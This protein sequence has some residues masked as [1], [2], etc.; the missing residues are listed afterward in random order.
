MSAAPDCLYAA[1]DT[2]PAPKGAA[3]HIR[4]FA[5]TLFNFFGNGL[6]LTLGAPELPSW[7]HEAGCEI[8][9]LASDENNYLKRAAEF[10]A[11]VGFHAGLLRN[12]LKIAHFRDPWGGLPILN[13]IAEQC[14]TVYE[15]NALP[16]IELP[17]RFR[18]IPAATLS[19]IIASEMECL[20]RADAVICPSEVIRNC[21]VGLGIPAEK[22][23]LIR[24]GATILDPKAFPRPDA[25]PE[26][27]L[28]YFGA[29][30]T[31]QGIECLFK[32]MTF[33]ADLPEFKL[34]LCAAG[35]KQR[36]KFL[37]KLAERLGISDRLIW[38]YRLS[39]LELYP[40]LANATISVSPLTECGRNLKQGCCPLK[41][42]E[43]MAMG[44]PVLASDLPVVRE[45]VEH[46]ITGWLTRADRPSELA[47]AIR[48]LL[49]HPHERHRI[50]ETARQ[51]AVQSLSWEKA[52]ES[53]REVYRRLL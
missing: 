38:Q 46:N 23:T 44:V 6:L 18:D 41:I 52:S 43:S 34:V 31:W 20:Q 29:V 47:R 45:L 27:Y 16:S 8:R 33:L 10:S 48:V 35:S 19:G 28:I 40:W 30:Q 11:F 12:D 49:A 3:V 32:A 37:N 24:N 39:Q 17:T 2:Y 13:S 15:V 14:R 42:V 7:Q 5:G 25:A 53:L 4:E 21:L 50:G 36:L 1:F 51:K 9:R 26:H 22:I